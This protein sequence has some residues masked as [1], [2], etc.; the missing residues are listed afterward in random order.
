MGRR[1]RRSNQSI[2]HF[3]SP[4][5]LRQPPP[6]ACSCSGSA[7]SSTVR[8][9]LSRWNCLVSN[10]RSHHPPHQRRRNPL[11]RP[12]PRPQYVHPSPVNEQASKHWR[13]Q[14]KQ[15]A[16]LTDGIHYLVGWGRSQ[17]DAFGASHDSTSVKA[18]SVDLI[19]SV[20]TVMRSMFMFMPAWYWIG[21]WL[22]DSAGAIVPLIGINS[23]IIVA[24]LIW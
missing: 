17:P 9:P 19:A 15:G 2:W 20:R 22:T 5:P 6:P 8:C 14:R 24:K 10:I 11:R 13:K 7:L 21:L 16:T 18:K 1:R 4:P 23:V 12:L 3:A